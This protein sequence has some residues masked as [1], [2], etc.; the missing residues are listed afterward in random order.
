MDESVRA[1]YVKINITDYDSSP[2]Y[3]P[4]V[5]GGYG[6]FE[7]AVLREVEINEDYGFS[8][9][10]SE[11]YPVICVNL[12]EQFYIDGHSL[13]GIDSEDNSTDWDNSDSNFCYSDSVLNDPKK[14]SFSN[15]GASPYYEQWVAI[16]RNTATNYSSGPD[17]RF[18]LFFQL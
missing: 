13:V 14:I 8:I 10:S 18:I 11:E 5:D 16:R 7:G 2:I 15:W 12:A 17:S 6:W 4:S 9:I 1:I 3:L